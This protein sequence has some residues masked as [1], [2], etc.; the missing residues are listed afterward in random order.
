MCFILIS[1]IR[2]MKSRAI[3]QYMHFRG[4]KLY[5]IHLQMYI[6]VIK[7]TKLHPYQHTIILNDK[8]PGLNFVLI[9]PPIDWFCFRKLSSLAFTNFGIIHGNPYSNMWYSSLNYDAVSF[10]K[11]KKKQL[12]GSSTM[13]DH[14]LGL[15]HIS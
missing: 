4:C 2:H 13:N 15:M 1:Y 6:H 5:R 9:Y 10:E 14:P 3:P 11:Q 12:H 7:N 8:I